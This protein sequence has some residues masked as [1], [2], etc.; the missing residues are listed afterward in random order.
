MATDD[1]SEDIN[2]FLLRIRELGDRRDREDEERTRKLEEE[3]LQGRKERQAR[4][5]ERARSISPIKEHSSNGGTPTSIKSTADSTRHDDITALP[6]N[7]LPPQ[8][9][10]EDTIGD[11]S[12]V[13]YEAPLKRRRPS[14][15]PNLPQPPSKPAT[16]TATSPSTAMAPSRAGTL[17]WQQRP[18]SR[19]S[20]GQ[21]ARPL[22]QFAAENNASRSPRASVEP[23]STIERELS[24]DEI[25]E[26][27][28][29][30][31]PTWFRQTPERGLGSAAYRRN[32]D[33]SMSDTLSSTGSMRLPGMSREL[34]VEP[35]R[36]GSPA[37][38][39]IR[40]LS[41]S[42]GGSIRNDPHRPFKHSS[43]ASLS[44]SN[45]IRSPLPIMNSH[46]FEPPMSK[47]VSTEVKDSLS[48]GPLS[49]SLSQGRVSPE[50]LDR[51]PSP[52]K[53]LGGFVQSAMLKRSDSVSKR[54]SAQ[55]AAGLSRGNS[56]ASNRSGYEA[57]K[58][59]IS[60]FS[61]P[62]EQIAN[63]SSPETS[64]VA[65]SKPGS[66]HSM[67]NVT[68]VGKESDKPSI[69]EATEPNGTIEQLTSTVK[70]P[71]PGEEP[72]SA[73]GQVQSRR[74]RTKSETSPPNSPSKR[75]SPTKSSW[76]ENAINKP[77]SPRPKMP[78]P[79][80]PP[81]MTNLNQAKQQR[82]ATDPGK[83]NNFKE[84]STGG[85]LRSPPMGAVNKSS[86]IGG[87]A[88]RPAGSTF[89][90]PR[91][92]S[93]KSVLAPEEEQGSALPG[94]TGTRSAPS[95]KADTIVAT[96]SLEPS[97][98][99]IASANTTPSKAVKISTVSESGEKKPSSPQLAKAKPETPPKKDFRSNLK[100]RQVS[101]DKKPTEEAEF[102]NV[103]GK[104]K[105]TQTQN[106]V[107]PD[108]LKDN[109]LRGKAG[110][111]STGDPKKTVRRDEFKES[112]L[113]QKEAMK[114]GP[115]PAVGRKPSADIATKI[116][117]TPQP[118]AS[119]NGEPLTNSDS[120]SKSPN[121]TSAQKKS[122]PE[123]LVGLQHLK[124]KSQPATV[125]SPLEA[126]A[127]QED[128][129]VNERKEFGFNS[130]LA[131]LLARGPSPLK[132]DNLSIPKAAHKPY[133]TPPI[134][135]SQS[136]EE[137]PQLT[138]M[139]KARARGPK[140]R[141]PTNKDAKE[142]KTVQKNF[143]FVTGDSSS[144]PAKVRSEPK[145]RVESAGT[146][147]QDSQAR[148][149]TTISNNHRKPSQP[150]SP[151]KS[152]LH[153]DK[154]GLSTVPPLLSQAS[155]NKPTSPQPRSP[156]IT[157]PK[158]V[159]ESSR[160][161][162]TSVLPNPSIPSDIP[163]DKSY[164]NRFDDD[165]PSQGIRKP[166]EPWPQNTPSPIECAAARWAQNIPCQ[167]FS[168][169][170]TKYPITQSTREDQN[171]AM[172]GLALL[173]KQEAPIGLGI[174]SSVQPPQVSGP[175]QH[176]LPTPPM[177]S[178]RSPPLPATK[179]PSIAKRI[180]STGAASEPASKVEESPIPQTSE[181]A[182]L[183][184]ELFD[185]SPN[186]DLKVNIDTPAVL[187]SRAP[188]SEANKI[189]TLRKQLW[190]V[191]AGGKLISVSAD[192]SHI[193]FEESMYICHHV[194]GSLSGTRTTEVYLWCGDGVA[195]SAVEDAQIFARKEAKDHG[196]RL[197]VLAQ[198]KET[199]N[200]FQAL[201]GIVI[202]RHG[203]SDRASSRYMLCGRR[204]LGQIAFDEVDFST[205]GLCKG[206]PYLISSG[207]GKVHLWKGSG[208]GV[209]ELG[210]ARLIGMDLGVHGEI[211][212]VE[213][214]REPDSFWNCFPGGRQQLINGSENSRNWRLKPSC[215]QYTT[216]LYRVDIEAPRPKSSSGFMW[217]RRGSAPAT[218]E[219]AAFSAQIK[220]IT[221]FAQSDVFN[222]GVFVLDTF[223]EIFVILPS[224]PSTSTLLSTFRT[225]LLFAQEYA[226]LAASAHDENRPFVPVSSVVL[227]GVG[228]DSVPEGL[229]M[230]FRKWEG[231]KVRGCRVLGLAASI[232]A[233]RPGG[234]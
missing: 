48:H 37:S 33:E 149:L 135:L 118:I 204:H 164:S 10:M 152:S 155:L 141:L 31:D 216:R 106:Y 21:R 94:I 232:E 24:K 138:H 99:K 58:Y 105:P 143:N 159:T 166:S 91:N 108:E 11:D 142:D 12:K 27:L 124:E 9:S 206:F 187:S 212:E 157:K 163:Q 154:P 109:I 60:S 130:S 86:S 79:Q 178:P 139:T 116:Q 3:I 88:S 30:K 196:G 53:G 147:K 1:G 205:Q 161:P 121:P 160:K 224:F 156:P 133:E 80:Q 198:G 181:A 180:I 185:E 70:L 2:D 170:R 71:S 4:R 214:G 47:S 231:G 68:Q 15:P 90:I 234:G 193:L 113:K 222:N 84:V 42:R 82:G 213:D 54:W 201:G 186:N 81:W 202:T 209:D 199:P 153:I 151:R 217:G 128:P 63:R 218:E 200:F 233:T 150:Q 92:N 129:P 69:L 101:S 194:F 19:G 72:A 95:P 171:V 191:T 211:E 173:P 8:A 49:T 65:S 162:S 119:L 175:A 184:A 28:G 103:F 172:Q 34:T 29:S 174:N 126:P 6:V 104:L 73:I 18:T 83:T 75:W 210:C 111:S 96:N 225:A 14:P 134:T 46:I 136:S 195:T 51:S 98:N 52:T 144:S 230:A 5:A 176:D 179:P 221:P 45:S 137:G 25:A 114:A 127:K 20:T 35:E 43:S 76:L 120:V 165:P 227:F 122:Q 32:Q 169:A 123:M 183:F 112:L 36:Q 66:S 182:R 59:A 64:P 219:N 97:S 39:S 16:L 40:S 132:G 85:L 190:E 23:P 55:P 226:I 229:R 57:S 192:Q 50:R 188:I 13:L 17:S 107:A 208:S 41:P 168:P 223:F 145:P 74:D 56:I 93:F 77:D 87:L 102:K 228:R 62:K 100:P 78:L 220:E 189:R 67:V 148:P 158:P 207:S 110:L 140:R 146:A 215:G 197:I 61:A 177:N 26:S 203:H 38:E 131:G 44:S 125:N 22:S 115:P 89:E 7:F 167:G 117:K